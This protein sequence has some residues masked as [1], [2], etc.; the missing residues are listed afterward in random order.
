MITKKILTN[1]RLVLRGKAKANAEVIAVVAECR[2]QLAM[3][4][5]TPAS[6]IINAHAAEL[7]L[8]AR[9]FNQLCEKIT[10]EGVK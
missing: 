8:D 3:D 1:A 7:G 2:R 10:G 4:F 5:D 6:V 9:E